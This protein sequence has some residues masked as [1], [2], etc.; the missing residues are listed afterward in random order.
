[1]L[2]MKYAFDGAEVER[3]FVPAFRAFLGKCPADQAAFVDEIMIYLKGSLEKKDKEH[4]MDLITTKEAYGYE[5]I[6]DAE[7]AEAKAL[8]E[9]IGEARLQDQ[10]LSMAKA[11]LLHGVQI[12][13]IATTTGLSEA[14]ILAL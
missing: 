4:F 10:K 6:A 2:A 14:E 7:L 13:I 12:Q 3:Y 5:T 1:M 9:A 8:G 11:L